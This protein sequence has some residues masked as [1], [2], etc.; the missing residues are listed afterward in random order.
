MKMLIAMIGFMVT[1]NVMAADGS[2]GCGP[3]WYV[4]KENSILSSSLRATT[5]G[6]LFPTT[7]LGMTLGTSNCS[8]HK[9]VLNEKKS[10]HF[11]THNLPELKSESAMG[12]GTYL[13]AFSEVVGCQAR[14]LPLLQQKIKESYQQV[15]SEDRPEK[16]LENIY[17]VIFS[18]T[19]L[20]NLCILS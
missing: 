13:S 1:A 7:T 15:F 17:R 18:D 11:V 2:S 3:G 5:N 16:V 19:Q 12:S 4:F 20:A 8:K 9:L 14:S 10:L 6:V